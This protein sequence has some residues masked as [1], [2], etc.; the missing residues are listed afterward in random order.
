[1]QKLVVLLANPFTK[2][3]DCSFNR[4]EDISLGVKI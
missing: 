2:F 4:T 1:M 3:E